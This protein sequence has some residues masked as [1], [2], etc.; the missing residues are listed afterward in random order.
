MCRWSR[1]DRNRVFRLSSDPFSVTPHTRSDAQRIEKDRLVKNLFRQREGFSG[2]EAAMG[3]L[4]RKYAE[5]F[6]ARRNLLLG[7]GQGEGGRSFQ[8][9][10]HGLVNAAHRFPPIAG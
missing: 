1:P 6:Q 4:S 3:W 2:G 7:K 8:L 9:N 10:N 5:R